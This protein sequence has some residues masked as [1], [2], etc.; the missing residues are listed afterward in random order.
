MQSRLGSLG[1]DEIVLGVGTRP[2]RVRMFPRLP[3]PTIDGVHIML[4]L[5][6]CA[7]RHS[8]VIGEPR[9]ASCGAHYQG[10]FHVRCRAV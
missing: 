2:G 5:D 8:S 4:L 10:T 3:R 9:L 6:C 7:L 1:E